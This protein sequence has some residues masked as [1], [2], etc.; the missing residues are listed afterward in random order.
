MTDANALDLEIVKRPK[1]VAK[2]PKATDEE[3]DRIAGPDGAFTVP[4]GAILV[5]ADNV[6]ADEVTDVDSLADSIRKVGLLTALEVRPA[7]TPGKFVLETGKRRWN[8]LHALAVPADWPVPIKLTTAAPMATRITRQYHENAHRR[9]LDAVDEA[10]TLRRLTTIHEM[11][12]TAAADQLGLSRPVATKRLNLLHLPDTWIVKVRSGEWD[13]EAAALAGQL[14]KAGYPKPADLLG[15]GRYRIESLRDSWKAERRF[16]SIVENLKARGFHPRKTL[17]SIPTDDGFKAAQ[18]RNLE[19]GSVKLAKAAKPEDVDS[20]VDEDGRPYVWVSKDWQGETNVWAVWAAE[21]ERRTTSG[22]YRDQERVIANLE[23]ERRAE[24][25]DN[26]RATGHQATQSALARRTVLASVVARSWNCDLAEIAGFAGLEVI[27]QGKY[28]DNSATAA[29]WAADESITAEAAD[30][31]LWA[32]VL[33]QGVRD[34]RYVDGPSPL[35]PDEEPEPLSPSAQAAIA[36]GAVP[37][38]IGDD[39]ASRLAALEPETDGDDTEGDTD[40]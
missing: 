20:I 19:I 4:F 7:G 18:G 26:I 30:L 23:T 33:D 14:I 29:A 11:S 39:F 22:V 1:R 15:V 25:F 12:V 9:N 13:I 27:R 28:V 40:E 5:A 32:I 10:E 34:L 24:V 8:A 36:A 21:S 38:V 17:A 31:V 6:R 35:D 37:P 16:D 3:L 2:I